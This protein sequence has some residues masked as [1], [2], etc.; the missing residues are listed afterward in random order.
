MDKITLKKEEKWIEMKAYVN[1]AYES[2]K[3]AYARNCIK[4]KSFFVLCNTKEHSETDPC[5]LYSLIGYTIAR[6]RGEGITRK[7]IKKTLGLSDASPNVSKLKGNGW[8]EYYKNLG[9]NIPDRDWM[10]KYNLKFN[11]NWCFRN[12]V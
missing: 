8:R 9:K 11:E 12:R 6:L 5:N 4:Q 7:E 1:F 2:K 3:F 10:F